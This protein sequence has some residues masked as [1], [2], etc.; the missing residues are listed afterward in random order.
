M[1]LDLEFQ[2]T[3]WIDWNLNRIDANAETHTHK[4]DN[5]K[6]QWP[7]EIH[8]ERDMRILCANVVCPEME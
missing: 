1:E 2:C 5:L 6:S 4:Q 3:S 7:F 8:I